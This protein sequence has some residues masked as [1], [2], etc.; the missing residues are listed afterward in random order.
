MTQNWTE[1]PERGSRF[2]LRAGVF[3]MNLLGYRFGV[4]LASIVAL[5]CF[6]TSRATR[7]ASRDYLTRLDRWSEGKTPTPTTRNVFRHHRE[8]AITVVD[9][10]WIWRGRY[11]QFE[12]DSQGAEHILSR[13]RGALIVGAHVGSFDVMRVIV[14]EKKVPLSVVMHRGNARRFNAILKEFGGDG[15]E[16][17]IVEID[18]GVSVGIELKK[19]VDRGELVA[20]LADRSPPGAPTRT[21]RA[22]FLG[23][24]ASLPAGPWILASVLGCEILFAR[25]VRVARRRYSVTVSSLSPEF[26]PSR[27]QRDDRA[28]QLAQS[29][30]RQL[31]LVCRKT[32]YQWFNF[33][34]FWD[35]PSKGSRT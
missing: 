10:F 22:S 32:P 13:D 15:P 6:L 5:Y 14:Q 17:G 35:V 20:L 23:E 3:G 16:I 25:A 19:R 28:S 18:D 8:F 34:D 4:F 24:D 2:L 27:A 30:V 7:R 31:E 33:F 11:E 12:I 9:R 1:I 21:C 29:Y 26:Q